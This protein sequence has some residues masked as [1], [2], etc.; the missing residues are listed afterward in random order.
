MTLRNI[1]TESVLHFLALGGVFTSGLGFELLSVSVSQV[2]IL[3][4]FVSLVA[5]KKICLPR[6]LFLA[7]IYA[8][9]VTVIHI[10]RVEGINVVTYIRTCVYIIAYYSYVSYLGRDKL[11]E[12]YGKYITG[13]Y[14]FSII[15]I[16]QEIGFLLHIPLLYDVSCIDG[17]PRNIV[18]TMGMLQVYSLTLE[19]VLFAVL[20][21]PC[22]SQIVQQLFVREEVLVPIS[23]RRKMVISLAFLLTFSFTAY[24]CL[25][26]IFSYYYLKKLNFSFRSV[27]YSL[28]IAGFVVSVFFVIPGNMKNKFE[29]LF[30]DREALTTSVENLSAFAIIS[31]FLVARDAADDHCLGTGFFTHKNNYDAY[32]NDHFTITEDTII[33]NRMDGGSMYIKVLSE[34]GYAGLCLFLLLFWMNRSKKMNNAYSLLN[35]CLF[36]TILGIFLRTADYVSPSIT[37][38]MVVFFFT[39]NDRLAESEETVPVKVGLPA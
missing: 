9:W 29:S 34:Y 26:F 3:L 21:L 25:L 17:M 8:L 15:A 13:C 11:P 24:V 33:L 10:G 37:Y 16:V 7:L 23:L 32:I 14:V 2:C 19:P 20:I 1:N 35:D 27:F 22:V 4:L 39:A 6:G 38:I 31:N 5:L 36:V 12:V 30:A 28:L 18:T